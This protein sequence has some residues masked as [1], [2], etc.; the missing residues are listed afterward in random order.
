MERIII[1]QIDFF[2]PIWRMCG[3]FMLGFIIGRIAAVLENDKNN[4]TVG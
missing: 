1:E 4:P 2:L 3:W